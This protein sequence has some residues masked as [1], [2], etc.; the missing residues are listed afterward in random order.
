MRRI[1]K[2]LRIEIL[3]LLAQGYSVCEIAKKFDLTEWQVQKIKDPR[4]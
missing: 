2:N 1:S 3:H 4:N